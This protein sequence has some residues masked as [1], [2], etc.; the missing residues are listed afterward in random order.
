MGVADI[1]L[2]TELEEKFGIPVIVQN[3]SA[4]V[5]WDEYRLGAGKDVMSLFSIMIRAGV[6]G[7]F[8]DDGEIFV[9]KTHTTLEIG[10]IAVEYDG[11]P[12]DCGSRGCLETYLSE[13]AILKDLESVVHLSSIDEIDALILQDRKD[14]TD[15]LNEKAGVLAQA[16]R[17]LISLFGPEMFLIVT[18]SPGLGRFLADR[19]RSD[20]HSQA[21][22]RWQGRTVI[23]SAVYNPEKA[24]RGAADLVFKNFFKA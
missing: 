1:S 18:R 16:V 4:A 21:S 13:G 8:L 19:V 15:I 9:T 14:V 20:V 6:G 23:E 24:G 11:R 2:R 3:N 10:H 22:E 17:N 12:C 5:A 7:A